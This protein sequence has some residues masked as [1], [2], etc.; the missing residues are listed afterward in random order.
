MCQSAAWTVA[1]VKFMG[2]FVNF[3]VAIYLN[4]S[5][6]LKL[7]KRMKYIIIFREGAISAYSWFYCG[8]WLEFEDIRFFGRMKTGGPGEKSLE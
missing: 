4:A 2:S 1:N 8:I 7:K 5:S 6:F 3:E